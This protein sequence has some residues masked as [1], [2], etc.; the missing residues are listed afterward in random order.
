MDTQPK[1]ELW[2]GGIANSAQFAEREEKYGKPNGFRTQDSGLKIRTLL[3]NLRLTP[4]RFESPTSIGFRL[5]NISSQFRCSI[6]LAYD[7]SMLTLPSRTS[8]RISSDQQCRL[9]MWKLWRN[10][11][12]RFNLKRILRRSTQRF[13]IWSFNTRRVLHLTLANWAGCI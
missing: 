13:A 2:G 7:V 10:Q 9:E 12:S 5:W 4:I 8:A 1:S 6:R 3:G 11:S